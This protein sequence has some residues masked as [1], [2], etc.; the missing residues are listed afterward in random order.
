M[1]FV[2]V[3]IVFIFFFSNDLIG[4]EKNG[5]TESTCSQIVSGV[6]KNRTTNDFIRDEIVKNSKKLIKMQNRKDVEKFLKNMF[7]NC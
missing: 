6:V 3:F 5:L 7:A 4:Q 1:K 2:K